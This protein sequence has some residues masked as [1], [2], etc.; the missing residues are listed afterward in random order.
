M[1][2][3]V[4]WLSTLLAGKGIVLLLS[5]RA[6][7]A[8]ALHAAAAIL[9]A[10]ASA[11]CSRVDR[12]FAYFIA[13]AIP[14][15]GA[16]FVWLYAIG[17]SWSS[18]AQVA[19]RFQE[20]IDA[21][22]WVSPWE[23]PVYRPPPAPQPFLLSP[24]VEILS[25]NA[26]DE[27]KRLAIE[28]L[29]KL[30]TPEAIESLRQALMLPSPEIR[31]YAASVLQRLE[32]RLALRLRALEEGGTF[33]AEPGGLLEAARAY[34]DY[35]YYRLADETRAMQFLEK[36]LRYAEE[37]ASRGCDPAAHLMRGRICLTLKRLDE[38]EGAFSRYIA[39]VPDDVKGRLWRAEA[40][41]FLGR[42]AGVREDC[43]AAHRMG[44]IP[45]KMREVVEMW[46]HDGIRRDREVAV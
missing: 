1:S 14:F 26:S 38:A 31:F 33:L 37:A 45:A 42:Y 18:S 2:V 23:I 30:E 17:P 27:E 9:A 43:E 5:G 28:G 19:R 44:G 15:A 4:G 21:T 36:A 34:Y 6:A 29:A 32:E 8:F 16:I 35:A 3:A 12:R 7:A 25:S 10:W 22:Q 40:R 39:L 13:F 20:R 24:M 11:R 46:T 41:F